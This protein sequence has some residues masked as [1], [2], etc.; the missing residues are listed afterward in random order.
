M[1]G[2][3]KFGRTHPPEVPVGKEWLRGA[4]DRDNWQ[5]P[6]AADELHFNLHRPCPATHR[7]HRS[8]R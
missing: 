6:P 1:E 5:M 7:V 3:S 8:L 4:S 2:E